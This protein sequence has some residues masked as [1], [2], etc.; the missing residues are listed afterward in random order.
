MSVGSRVLGAAAARRLAITFGLPL[1]VLLG[2]RVPSPGLDVAALESLGLPLDYLNPL[3]LGTVPLVSAYMVVE[4]GALLRKPWRELRHRWPEGRARME[5]LV[6]WIALVLAALQ[7]FAM[8]MMVEGMGEAGP[9]LLERYGSWVFGLSLVAGAATV[10]LASRAVSA[11]GLVNGPILLSLLIAIDQ[12]L[13]R[14]FPD[15]G[16]LGAA[17]AL[18]GATWWVLPREQPADSGGI[19]IVPSLASSFHPAAM[20]ANL[21]A[22]FAVLS[23]LGVQEAES[24]ARITAASPVQQLTQLMLSLTASTLLMLTFQPPHVVVEQ[25]GSDTSAQEPVLRSLR[26]ALPSTLLYTACAAFAFVACNARQFTLVALVAPL[27]ALT[28]DLLDSWRLIGEELVCIHEERRTY[29]LGATQQRLSEAGVAHWIVDRHQLVGQRFF[30]PFIA[31]RV[32]V[33][34]ADA[35]AARKLVIATAPIPAASS[36]SVVDAAAARRLAALAFLTA[37]TCALAFAPLSS[38]R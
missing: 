5:R 6:V 10:I 34:P 19:P 21:P 7:A 38:A 15:W 13:P 28:L 4:V 18:G 17:V 36:L 16:A 1:L 3:A 27:V 20:A 2:K 29:C 14:S 37:V 24:W 22:W 11:Q 31:A 35:E 8:T 33:K 26:A 30:A 12:S 25:L 23:T 32:L 9:A